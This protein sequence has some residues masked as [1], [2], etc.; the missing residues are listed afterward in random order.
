[1]SITT[2]R[3]TVIT[4][5]G[6]VDGEEIID[7]ADNTAGVGVIERYDLADGDND[8]R[9]PSFNDAAATACTIVPLGNNASALILKGA[10][11]D[12]GIRLH[13]TD[14]TTIAVHSTQ[15]LFILNT[16]AES[17]IVVRLFWS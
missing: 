17:A 3:R 1:M 9:V 10:S 6:D 11:G 5:S 4:H 2:R 16:P 13:N 12:T 7:A 15:E 14:P 8:I